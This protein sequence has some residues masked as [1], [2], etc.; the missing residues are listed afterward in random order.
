MRV[1]SPPAE[2]TWSHQK[3]GEARWGSPLEPS[4]GVQSCHH[5]ACGL[6]G[7]KEF[8]SFQATKSV[9]HHL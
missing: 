5:F 4:E 9:C 1:M 7:E 8:L 6:Q 3:L 2:D